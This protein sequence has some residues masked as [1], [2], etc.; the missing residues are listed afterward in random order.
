MGEP[1]KIKELLDAQK[2]ISKYIGAV[3]SRALRRLVYLAMVWH[4]LYA[5]RSPYIEVVRKRNPK[6][7]LNWRNWMWS[8]EI[9]D[10]MQILGC[11]RRTA[12]DY[13]EA[14]LKMLTWT[15]L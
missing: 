4:F 8:I 5:H 13:R 14:Y 11:S 6:L 7:P 10:V 12:W 3:R 15:E 9:D 2:E 1:I